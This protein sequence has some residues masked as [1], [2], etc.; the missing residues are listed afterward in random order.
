MPLVTATFSTGG[1]VVIDDS[2]AVAAITALTNAI[3]AQNA[4]LTANF[5]S[6]GIKTPGAPVALMGVTA[7]SVTDIASILADIS[8]ALG[9]LNK[10]AV[11][12]SSAIQKLQLGMASIATQT[13]KNGVIAQ[14]ALTDQIKNN[15]FQQK[16][17][18]QAL[19]DAGK[20]PTVVTPA[21]ILTKIQATIQDLTTFN[22]EA[23]ISGFVVTSIQ[24]GFT[25]SYNY[26]TE[27][28]SG[29][30]V[31]QWFVSTWTDIKKKFV[32]VKAEV[33][34][35]ITASTAR[36]KAVQ[37]SSA[38]KKVITSGPTLGA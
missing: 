16:T 22:A 31:S 33:Q 23:S 32:T 36:S 7:D 35:E 3:L 28:I 6:A 5:T 2:V 14:M 21:N 11:E 15:E 8:T 27:W 10:G 9:D 1:N 29:T 19:A 38:A 37:T 12:S 34:A 20:P 24:D 13:A 25:F 18:N 26:V 4:L 17:T 30:A